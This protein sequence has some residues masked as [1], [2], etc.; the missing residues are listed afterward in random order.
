MH[1]CISPFEKSREAKEPCAAR[2]ASKP[3]CCRRK[4]RTSLR[5][6]LVITGRM[7]AIGL[8]HFFALRRLVPPG[9]S[10]SRH[11][12]HRTFSRLPSSGFVSRSLWGFLLFAR[13]G[14]LGDRR[15]A[16]S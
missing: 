5:A 2:N 10:S 8:P 16:I 11:V 6:S 4:D 13:R 12:S 3:F 1:A 7:Y 14:S 15:R 9:R